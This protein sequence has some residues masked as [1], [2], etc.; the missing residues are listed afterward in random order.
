MVGDVDRP[1]CGDVSAILGASRPAAEPAA[2]GRSGLCQAA[3]GRGEHAARQAL[4]SSPAW[5]WLVMQ[6]VIVRAMK[7]P[8]LHPVCL[9]TRAA[10]LPMRNV[11]PVKRRLCLQ[12]FS[13]ATTSP[14]A[15]L[16]YLYPAVSAR[17]F[18]EHQ[19][20]LSCPAV[21]GSACPHTHG[22]RSPAS[23]DAPGRY[24]H[25]PARAQS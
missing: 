6:A 25:S 24:S 3:C 8:A 9:R 20:K 4:R 22:P 17:T 5:T 13:R 18:S 11:G 16:I 7:T 2:D 14:T 10:K 1:R 21:N 23:P 19:S 12:V 15:V